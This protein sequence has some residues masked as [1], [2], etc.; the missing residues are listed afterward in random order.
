MN[1]QA[2]I[3]DVD[4]LRELHEALAKFGVRAREALDVAGAELRRAADFLERQ[5]A[6]WQHEVIRRREDLLRAKADLSR[7]RW[8]HDGERV[9]TS[10]KELAVHRARERLREAEEKG[11]AVRRWQRTLP[12]VAAEYEGPARRLAGMLEADLR[13]GLA[14]LETRSAALE[15]YLALAPPEGGKSP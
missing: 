7:Q 10:E 2:K 14:L 9:G 12:Q 11:E 8:L 5:Q 1:H 4:S 13:A 3:H 6:Y 15:A